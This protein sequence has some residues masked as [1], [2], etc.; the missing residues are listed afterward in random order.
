MA[1]KMPM[2]KHQAFAFA[3]LPLLGAVACAALPAQAQSGDQDIA[4]EAARS[5]EIL[6]LGEIIAR[7]S[8]RV[9]GR[10]VGAQYDPQYRI[11]RL[12]FLRGNSVI[13]VDVDAATGRVLEIRGE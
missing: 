6:P 13:M 7:V 2:S 9:D 11:Y 10:Y 3:L 4:F 12:K 8:E 5:G 1:Q